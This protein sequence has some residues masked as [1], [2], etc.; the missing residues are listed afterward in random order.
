MSTFRG[1]RSLGSSETYGS[2]KGAFPK[3]GT[4]EALHHLD[5]LGAEGRRRGEKA[6]MGESIVAVYARPRHYLQITVF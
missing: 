3:D 5:G 4:L 1:R 2:V 6:T